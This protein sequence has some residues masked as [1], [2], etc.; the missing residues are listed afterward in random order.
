VKLHT[1]ECNSTTFESQCNG[2]IIII[3]NLLLTVM[4]RVKGLLITN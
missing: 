2:V 3:I 1:N 4:L